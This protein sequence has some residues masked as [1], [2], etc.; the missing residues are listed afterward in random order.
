M[1]L[2]GYAGKILRL[3][4]SSGSATDSSTMDYADRFLGG[5]GIAAK[6]Y[7]DEVSPNANP[8]D[9][10]NR[11]VFVTGPFGGLPVLGGSRWQVCGKSPATVPAH[12][13]YGNFGGRWGAELK[14]A[15]YDAIVVQG[16]SEKPVYLLLNDNNAELRDASAIW[17]KGA[18]ETRQIL[19]NE[20]GNS[21]KIV[22][23]GPAG[24]NRVVIAN[25]LAENDATGAKGLGAVMGSK[26]LKAIVVRGSGSRPKVAQPEKLEELIKRFRGL[27]KTPHRVLGGVDV[28][29]TGPNVRKDHCY[30]CLGNCVRVVY[31]AQNGTKGKFMC[32]SAF[33]YRA[34]A[35]RYY[36]EQND[37][38]F[39]VNRLCD[40]YGIDTMPVEAIIY[41]LQRCH[42][43]GILTEENTGIPLSKLGSMEFI[44]TLLRKLSLREGFGDVLA[45]GLVKAAERV[46]QGS[47]DLLPSFL[48]KGD[49]PEMYGPR[50]YNTHALLYAMEP[51]L[52]IQQLHEISHSIG[53]W[54]TWLQN[55]H[56][57]YVS[58]D[59][60]R[61]IAA[62]FWGSEMAADF[63][64]IEGKALAAIK[65]QDRQYAKECLGLC[66][67]L[68]PV[69]DIEP[70]E[71]HVGDP[72]LESQILSAVSGHEIDEEGLNR[73]GE[74]VFNLQ[75]SVLVREGH[76]GRKSDTLPDRWHTAPLR[77]DGVN[78]ECLVPGRG[79][80]VISRKGA[81]VD[82]KEFERMKDEYYELRRWDIAT[83]LQTRATLEALG[84][85]EIAQDMGRRGLLPKKSEQVQ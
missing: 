83:G 58:T 60:L 70:S 80:E 48:F 46:G 21:V 75:R 49:Q 62:K 7:W 42:K 68:W 52:P 57:G 85:T 12:F 77:Y 50:L 44:E 9:E 18:A 59:V 3:D 71:S 39:Y 37:V 36:G 23:I 64:T 43:A 20:W 24:E 76:D 61:G 72:T 84:L 8:F 32:S 25:L 6:I 13:S 55:I 65:I 56:G 15:G 38:A 27:G 22:A 2:F 45:D 74:R 33:V 81:V 4:L 47:E 41:W 67:F 10:E 1:E 73:I 35:Q 54:L 19:K 14:F 69:I 34:Y 40:D 53:K 17:G 11:L 66:D 63:S 30:G 78:V 5:R 16:K 79:G 31:E 82:R 29:I 26:K 28:L 51:R